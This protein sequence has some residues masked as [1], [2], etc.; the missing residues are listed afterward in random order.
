MLVGWE[1]HPCRRPIRMRGQIRG[2]S[3]ELFSGY[4]AGGLIQM[5]VG[6]NADLG[7]WLCKM[8]GICA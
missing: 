1:Q 7:D 5:M 4:D 2:T 8:L 3:M 6:S